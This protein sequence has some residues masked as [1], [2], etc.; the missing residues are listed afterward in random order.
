M[1]AGLAAEKAATRTADLV[2]RYLSWLIARH[3]ML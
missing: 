3:C 1:M 2:H